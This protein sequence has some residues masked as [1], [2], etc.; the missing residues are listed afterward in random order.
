[1]KKYR[2]VPQSNAERSELTLAAV[3]FIVTV[4]VVGITMACALVFGFR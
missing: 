3:A 2:R 4:I 1:M